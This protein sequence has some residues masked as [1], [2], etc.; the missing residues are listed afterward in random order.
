MNTQ[1][2]FTP[3]VIIIV[4]ILLLAGGTA[5]YAT[6][7]NQISKQV[8]EE[9]NTIEEGALED[10]EQTMDEPIGPIEGEIS[11]Y[12]YCDDSDS[13]LDYH[14]RGEVTY[15]TVDSKN[16]VTQSDICL[17]NNMIQ[18]YY[19]ANGV[20]KSVQFVCENG[21]FDAICFELEVEPDT[22]DLNHLLVQ[23]SKETILRYGFS[24]DF[25][26][27]HFTLE[28][29]SDDIHVP[30]G[31]RIIWKFTMGDYVA[32]VGDALGYRR[33]GD[34]LTYIHGIAPAQ[35]LELP[36]F[37][38]FEDVLSKSE[39]DTLMRSCIGEF[40]EARAELNLLGPTHGFFYVASPAENAIICPSG[41]E[42][43]APCIIRT[44]IVDLIEGVAMQCD[45]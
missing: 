39:A 21:C 14:V 25:F 12:P 36:I 18:E 7:T 8:S 26:D 40:T 19:C 38:D 28:F 9:E 24:E 4:V 33:D 41:D 15:C 13:G 45:R 30:G 5:Y 10:V 27:T 35:T 42:S 17:D 16:C 6:N 1:K 32:T 3:M 34:T 20:L 43:A 29:F 22:F 11:Q 37:S 23:E 44:G 31:P 2:G